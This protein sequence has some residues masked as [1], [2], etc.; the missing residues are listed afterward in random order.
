MR[1]IRKQTE[2]AASVEKLVYTI[3]GDD[4]DSG[5]GVSLAAALVAVPGVSRL[6]INLP[7]PAFRGGQAPIRNLLPAFDGAVFAWV[8]SRR[9]RGG[10]EERLRQHGIGFHG[11]AVC[12][13]NPLPPRLP[14]ADASGRVDALSQL[15]LLR[16]PQAMDYDHWLA[17][18]IDSHTRVAI[19]CQTTIAYL[20]N[21]VQAPVTANAPLLHGIVEECFPS[22][23]YADPCLF[24]GAPGDSQGMQRN[25]QRLMESTARF[26]PVEQLD[27]IFTARHLVAGSEPMA[28]AAPQKAT[29]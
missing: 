19:E 15:C 16:K 1:R 23:A 20:Q 28:A 27:R 21:I 8:E 17:T 25:V 18:W 2:C 14:E 9:D 24:F 12:E 13:S 6:Q 29:R 22:A 3:W 7:D 10:L 5:R 11:Y 26:A 4:L